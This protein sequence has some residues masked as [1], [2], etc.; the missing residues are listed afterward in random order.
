MALQVTD[1]TFDEEVLKSDI[2]VLV[3]FWAPWCGPCRAMGPVIDE[4]ASEYEGKVKISKMN[5]DENPSTPSKYGIRA[6]PTLILFKD[7]EVVEQITGAVSK[8]SIKE[9]ITSKAL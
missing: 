1:G 8:S 3:D 5:V 9:M 7:G 4:M 6:I 2:P